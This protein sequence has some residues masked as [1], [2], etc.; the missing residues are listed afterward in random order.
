[1]TTRPVRVAVIDSGVNPAHPHVGGAAGGVAVGADGV[2]SA[3]Y[4]DRMG[5][6]TAVAAAIRERAPQ[7]ELFAVKVFDRQ[8]SAP[9]E[10]LVEAIDWA[11]TRQVDLINLSLG[12][13]NQAHAAPLRSA[14]ARAAQAVS[15][16]SS[17]WSSTGRVRDWRWMWCLGA[18]RAT[19]CV[20]PLAT[21]DRRRACRRNATSKGSVSLW[22]T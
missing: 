12:T 19:R 5:H 17:R 1:M 16:A 3:D 7:A 13:A 8:L 2:T 11:A 4:I 6:G 15:R 14:V 9:I 20:A 18:E 21:R 10:A 22:R